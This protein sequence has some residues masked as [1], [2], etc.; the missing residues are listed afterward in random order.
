MSNAATA[1]ATAPARPTPANLADTTPAKPIV[2]T[3][4]RLFIE[5]VSG[6]LVIAE[7]SAKLPVDAKSLANLSFELSKAF[8]EVEASRRKAALLFAK[9]RPAAPRP[10]IHRSPTASRRVAS[11]RLANQFRPF[12]VCGGCGLYV[13]SRA[14]GWHC[15]CRHVYHAVV[16]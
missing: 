10:N 3:A 7:N 16:G 11:E 15:V 5:L 4:E 14:I 12:L 13:H 1:T 9:D 2:A 6:A 8:H